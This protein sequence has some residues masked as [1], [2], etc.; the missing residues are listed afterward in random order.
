VAVHV[1][2][3]TELDR[4]SIDSSANDIHRQ[5]E[6]RGDAAGQAY[7]N[8]FAA[9]FGRAA[10]KIQKAYEQA[11]SG[12]EKAASSLRAAEAQLSDVRRKAEDQTQKLTVAEKNLVTLR[13]VDHPRAQA[14]AATAE[15][16]LI[17]LREQH[18]STLAQLTVRSE[19]FARANIS[20]QSALTDLS[21][22]FQAVESGASGAAGAVSG[23]ASSPAGIAVL[24][25]GFVQ[26]A[27]VAS[28]ASGAI[29]LLPGVIGGAAAAMG[30]LK[31]ATIGFDQA[32]KDVNS[33]KKFADDLQALSP[34][35]QQAALAIQA[36]MP[37]F[38]E[39]Q[40]A[41]E[42]TL[43]TGIAP[44]LNKLADTLLPTVRTA[45]TGIA[46]AMNEA[47]K[48]LSGALTSPGVQSN[49]ATFVD[50]I[51]SAFHQLAPAVA[52]IT[53][54]ISELAA[55][56]SSFMPQLASAAANAANAFSNFVSEASRS[57]ELKQWIN[58]G[59]V[60]MRQMATVV[61]DLGQAFLA[62]GPIGKSAMSG[63]VWG[64]HATSTAVR[65]LTGDLSALKDVFPSIGDVAVKVFNLINSAIDTILQGLRGAIDVANYFGAGIPQIPHI[66]QATT[67]TIS[68][69]PGA[70]GSDR[71]LDQLGINRTATAGGGSGNL[72]PV[73]AVTGPG[74]GFQSGL[75]STTLAPIPFVWGQPAPD[76]LKGSAAA[77]A[78]A[79]AAKDPFIDPSQWQV[80]MPGGGSPS[81]T[82]AVVPG[83]GAPGAPGG[84]F[85]GMAPGAAGPM[86]P[87]QQGY[88]AFGQPKGF[89]A[90]E[91]D[92]QAVYSAQ[93]EQF[94]AHNTLEQDK[95]HLAV[96]E[97]KGLA[98][99]EE[100]LS[101]RN[102]VAEDERAFY[103]SQFKYQESLQGKW[104]DASTKLSSG[105]NQIGAA[106]DKDLGIS[107]GLAGI[108]DNL[109]K[110]LANLAAA[111]L[112]GQLNAVAQ[113]S[114]SQGG[115][116][117]MGV[118]GAQG[119]F[120]PQ[121]TGLPGVGTVGAGPFGLSPNAVPG[122]LRALG[123]PGG[124]PGDAA[125]LANI[126]AGQYVNPGGTFDLSKGLADC[127][128]AVG[129]LVKT[130]DGTRTGGADRLNTG[131]AP[132]WL[133]AHGFLPGSAPGAF[134][135]G[136]NSGHM[137]ATLP[138]GTPFNWGSDA[139]AANR[140]IGGTGAFDPAFT[141][142][143]YR[144]VGA[145][146]LSPE[147][148]NAIMGAEA[149]GNGGWG[150][151]TGNGYYGG[152]Q[153]TPQ[154]WNAY[155]PPGAPGQ[156]DLATPQ[157]QM[158]AGNATLAAQGSGAWPATSAAHPDW[159]QP[160]GAP[161]PVSVGDLLAQGFGFG[162]GPGSQSPV[163]KRAPGFDTTNPPPLPPGAT[164]WHLG[165]N[166]PVAVDGQGN[167]I[168]GAATRSPFA[169]VSGSVG[170]GGSVP[171]TSPFDSGPLAQIPTAGDQFGN[172]GQ[173]WLPA[174]Q[175]MGI[176]PGQP[177][178][179]QVPG[180]PA[181]A[182]QGAPSAP[183]PLGGVQ[184]PSNKSGGQIGIT[185][186][187]TLDTA[188]GVAASG[189]D[190]IAPGAGQAAQTG[191][192]EINRA[193]QFAGQA[194]GIGVQGALDML[195]PWG[196]SDLASKNWLIR[197]LAGVAGAAPALPNMAGKAASA[198]ANQPP[199]GSAASGQGSGQPPGPGI[200]INY[201]NNQATEDRA[202]ADIANHLSAQYPMI[203]GVR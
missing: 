129:D 58:D 59:I 118:L 104:K 192:K 171:G 155:K 68:G 52:P 102:K 187:G 49:I 4:R 199:P 196:G 114:P 103:E 144:P 163:F 160:A 134:N 74:S 15:R 79:A 120:G 26:L 9:G 60:V 2:V 193:I 39:L 1:D 56:G 90:Y 148:W 63:I 46:S 44:Q 174:P 128:S 5:L 117:L 75:A 162:A 73:P 164:A 93:S 195:I 29:G 85:P 34:N 181:G 76:Y 149:G 177:G 32:L 80:P 19:A 40:K 31:L 78:A 168:A 53:R 141:S 186:G 23:L 57:G 35:A 201:T 83:P 119:A 183:T 184:P 178:A 115:F 175:Q 25:A 131:N 126:P 147:Q 170:A 194:T 30:T 130:L 176:L 110:F 125:L 133:T 37:A 111:P 145:G 172:I 97:K 121:F 101:A 36:L 98:S 203:S 105:M 47:F 17:A 51:T 28:T 62:L 113:S 72:P 43:F 198:P 165:P 7:G 18:S 45:T 91:V 190:L 8:N 191:I 27:S 200:T 20:Q 185:P 182:P 16:E 151:N 123:T 189:L 86:G 146:G 154:T 124:Y 179:P 139:A 140:G 13:A 66:A 84:Q 64:V 10:P 158:A 33:P 69:A 138:G 38:T 161:G 100:L 137:Q 109:V 166:G 77:K 55:V 167:P 50:N 22:A 11:Y 99:Q 159:F 54:A 41:S 70:S 67:P 107:K 122:A 89:G 108:A 173:P 87:L 116:G 150:A 152:L 180:Q 88:N 135:V 14:L 94:R 197:G 21:K 153:F 24:A 48:G 92:P 156:A 71:S 132:E 96:I 106:L 136:F 61:G 127:S 65:L 112:L 6:Q 143:Y 82:G 202:G 3:Y 157:Q 95:L 12:A 81:L 169:G 42:E 188:I 142:H